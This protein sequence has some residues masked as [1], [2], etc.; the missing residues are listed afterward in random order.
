MSELLERFLADRASLDADEL[1]ALAAAL[2]ADPVLAGEAR[3]QLQ[4]DELLSRRHAGDR[5]HFAARVATRL[6]TADSGSFVRR[7]RRPLLLRRPR[8]GMRHQWLAAA[9]LLVVIA[10]G[11]LLQRGPGGASGDVPMLQVRTGTVTASGRAVASGAMLRAGADLRVDGGT[12]TLVWPDGTRVELEAGAHVVLT[13]TTPKQLRLTEGALRAD[14][15]KQPVGAPM[16]LATRDA[17]ATVLGTR[18]RLAVGRDSR[19]DVLEGRVAFGNASGTVEVGGDAMATCS[20]G[21]APHLLRR[22]MVVAFGRADRALPAGTQEDHGQEF[23]AAR[24]YGWDR[25]NDGAPLPGVIWMG[26]PRA[27]DRLQVDSWSAPDALRDSGLAVGWAGFA[28]GWRM[29]L[30]DGRYDLTI[31][32]GGTALEQ[33]PHHVLAQGQVVVDDV[34]TAARAVRELTA[35]VAVTDGWLRLAVGGTSAPASS[36]GSSDT[37]I[38][39]LRI[40]V[41]E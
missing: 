4:L 33:G 10:G 36:D 17:L 15:A 24:G 27:S 20:A 29:A 2:R 26:Q 7:V 22:H 18:L 37:L 11:I 41:A 32:V 19:L 5:G 1:T 6:A 31:A 16:T 38:C 13:A 28:E 12:A 35:R 14:V 3:A 23:S 30:P 9:A 34:I 21:Q 40:A 8:S 39:Y 25:A